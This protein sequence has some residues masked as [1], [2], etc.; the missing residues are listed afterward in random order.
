M[1]WIFLLMILSVSL[2]LNA[3]TT[4]YIDSLHGEDANSGTSKAAPWKTLQKVNET[5]FQPGTRILLKSGSEWHG[6]LA[7]KSS[8]S[9]GMPIVIAR[10][11]FFSLSSDVNRLLDLECYRLEGLRV[12]R[13]RDF[14]CQR[15]R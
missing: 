11:A 10:Y 9:P 6:Q 13:K 12:C 7:P 3:A 14:V 1:R 5:N 8:G 4:Y 2:S 15:R